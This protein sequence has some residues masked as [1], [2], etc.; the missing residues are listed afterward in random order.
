M[1]YVVNKQHTRTQLNDETPP[2]LFA[3][4][5]D[6]SGEF[7]RGLVSEQPR[8]DLWRRRKV[9]IQTNNPLYILLLNLHRTFSS[10]I[11]HAYAFSVKN[12]KICH[13]Q[14]PNT[15]RASKSDTL[16]SNKVVVVSFFDPFIH[17]ACM[18]VPLSLSLSL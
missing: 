14:E 6:H 8:E 15:A 7:A 1:Q 10:N 18:H 16:V 2:I 13:P 9:S 3:V 17:H 5:H 11:Y 4:P 12:I